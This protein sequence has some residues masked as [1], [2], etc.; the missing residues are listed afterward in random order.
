MLGLYT[1]QTAV[2]QI[3]A[4][5]TPSDKIERAL[6]KLTAEDAKRNK[7]SGHFTYRRPDM[8]AAPHRKRDIG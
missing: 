6:T 1:P 7:R 8:I 5:A 4:E 2:L 3:V